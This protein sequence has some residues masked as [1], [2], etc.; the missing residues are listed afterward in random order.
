MAPDAGGTKGLLLDSPIANAR[1][2]CLTNAA[3]LLELDIANGAATANDLFIMAEIEGEVVST[4]VV[5]TA[6]A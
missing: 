5:I 2:V 3:G 1:L 4:E 6:G